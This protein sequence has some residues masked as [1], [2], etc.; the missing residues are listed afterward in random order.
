MD[1]RDNKFA[2]SK[3]YVTGFSLENAGGV[4]GGDKDFGKGSVYGKIYHSIIEKVVLEVKG[5]IGLAETYGSTDEMPIYERYF[6]GG[7]TTIRGYE[8]R[9]VGPRDAGSGEALGGETIAIGN[10]EVS[11]PIYRNVI[12]GAVFYDAGNVWADS[13]D[14]LST[15]PKMGAGLGVR[16]KTPIGP[17]KLDYGYPLS[18]NHDDKKEG[19][20]YF[21]VSHGF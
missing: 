6:A 2:P 1:T 5:S 13:S 21:S 12:K 9:R 16:V 4:I 10:A 17:L 3:G 20:F 19:Q 18:K 11:F 7:A 14:M 15:A 8:Q